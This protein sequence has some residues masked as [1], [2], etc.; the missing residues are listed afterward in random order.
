MVDKPRERAERVRALR[1]CERGHALLLDGRFGGVG[2]DVRELLDAAIDASDR[3]IHTRGNALLDLDH[4]A[5][6]RRDR[7]DGSVA[8]ERPL[9]DRTMR[10]FHEIR[11]VLDRVENQI[12]ETADPAHEEASLA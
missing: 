7:L 5:R 10:A 9:Y 3:G 6:R 4:G 11:R 2:A 8:P 1:R 12:L